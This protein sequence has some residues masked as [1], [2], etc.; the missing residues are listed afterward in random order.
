MVWSRVEL[1]CEIVIVT[2]VV[3]VLLGG[4]TVYFQPAY[5]RVCLRELLLVWVW[6]VEFVDEVWFES[7]HG[8]VGDVEDC[9]SNGELDEE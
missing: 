2:Q 9:E 7:L 6:W 3:L 1:G 8:G 5:K 4:V